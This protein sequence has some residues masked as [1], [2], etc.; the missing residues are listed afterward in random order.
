MKT[1][2][3]GFVQT[4]IDD[5]EVTGFFIDLVENKP[6]IVGAELITTAYLDKLQEEKVKIIT[7]DDAEM[8]IGVFGIKI[9]E[10]HKTI[11]KGH[12]ISKIADRYD[13]W[14]DAKKDY[15]GRAETLE[16]A[17]KL[18]DDRSLLSTGSK[19]QQKSDMFTYIDVENFLTNT[20]PCGEVGQ[21][22]PESHVFV[23]YKSG[24]DNRVLIIKF[25]GEDGGVTTSLIYAD[26]TT[27]NTRK[28]HKEFLTWK[29]LKDYIAKVKAIPPSTPKPSKK[30]E[31]LLPSQAEKESKQP[32]KS[33]AEALK[34]I[35]NK[36]KEFY[37]FDRT[38]REAKD[39]FVAS[40]EYK[41]MYPFI[42]ALEKA[43]QEKHNIEREKAMREAGLN[44]G[45]KVET[46][47][48]SF[49]GLGGN[50]Y[51]GTLIQRAGK[52]FVKL[53]PGSATMSGRKL[54][55]WN[56]GWEK[57]KPEKEY[58]QP[59]EDKRAIKIIE[60]VAKRHSMNL[61]STGYENSKEI[62]LDKLVIRIW[63]YILEQKDGTKIQMYG[64]RVNDK[65]QPMG[66]DVPIDELENRL[67]EL[68]KSNLK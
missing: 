25:M 61:R 39:L 48:M 63:W 52:P 60:K 55:E 51:T 50:A 11:Y 58:V 27:G 2:N 13:I 18:V 28:Q 46:F 35:E 49:T 29:R 26:P 68:I 53:D 32:F 24:K 64:F 22:I 23:T 9:P 6:M 40:D 8:Y 20:F 12:T 14:D 3:I 37:R 10:S 33:Y 66:K 34:W 16:E 5:N 67:T 62:Y 59:D 4:K 47:S 41:Q 44:Y 38:K 19:R 21:N 45:D 57:L 30:K 36:T 43:E 1:M 17:K 54:I 15:V 7:G 65:P 56:T 42:K 31:L